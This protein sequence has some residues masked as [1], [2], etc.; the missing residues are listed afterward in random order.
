MLL[1]SSPFFG[2]LARSRS[3]PNA[4]QCGQ[5]APA[6]TLPALQLGLLG[7]ASLALLL[8]W[9]KPWTVLSVLRLHDMQVF[10]K[11]CALRRHSAPLGMNCRLVDLPPCAVQSFLVQHRRPE[12]SELKTPEA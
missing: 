7:S 9:R 8:H 5:H 11:F 4:R 2:S 1:D 6:F 10:G 3:R 12:R